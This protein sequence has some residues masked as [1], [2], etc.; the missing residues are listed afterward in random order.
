MTQ[1]DPSKSPLSRK[2]PNDAASAYTKALYIAK[3]LAGTPGTGV[4][5]VSAVPPTVVGDIPVFDTTD[6]TV[7]SDSGFNADDFSWSRRYAA[8]G[9]TRTLLSRHSCVM[10]GDFTV[11]AGGTLVIESDANFLII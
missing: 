2:D 7:I 1:A 10:A 11:E 5:N 9:E 6:G 4:G 3:K 8:N